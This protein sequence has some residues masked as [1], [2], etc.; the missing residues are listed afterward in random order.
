MT[1]QS[2]TAGTASSG[3]AIYLRLLGY[4]RPYWPYFALSILGYV[5]FAASQPMFPKLVDYFTTALIGDA[6]EPVSIW[7]LGQVAPEKL[8][9]IVPLGM[10]FIA[11]FRGIGSFMGNYFLARVSLGVVHDLRTH[12]FNSMLVLPNKFFDDNNSGHLI[13][14]IT[15]NVGGVTTA[16]TDAIKVVVREGLTVIA[17][18]G[19]LL[20]TN[21]KLTLLFIAIMPVIAGVVALTSKRF[22][23]LSKKIQNTMGD[24]THIASETI[25]SHRVVRSFG[26]ET[27]EK[28]RFLA[29]SAD[30]T[31]KGLKMVK[32]GAIMTPTLQLI[33]LCAMAALMY[34]VLYLQSTGATA[35]TPGQL[36]G[37]LT[38]AGLLP[39]PLRQLSEVIPN[40]QKGIVA[41]HSVFELVDEETEKDEGT[42]EVERVNG[43]LEI[44]NLT[45]TY[46]NAESPALKD[47]NFTI[48]P[49]ETIALV[50][51]SGSGKTTL[52]SLLPRFYNHDGGEILLD[53]HPIEDYQLKNLRKQI[54][55]VNQQVS[56][57]NDTVANNIA[58][59]DL[60]DTDEDDIRLAARSA[61]AMEF[62]EN[63]PEGLHTLVG[64]NG[65]LLSG[66]QRQRLA[67][68][69]AILKDAP[70]LI[71]DEATSALDTES[72]RHIQSALDNIMKNRTTL[73]IAHRLST[74][75]N[76]DR[77][78]VM[79]KG[80]IIESGTHSEL[81]ARDGAYAR[82]HHL[83]FEEQAE[84]V[85]EIIA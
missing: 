50:G 78:L 35:N 33:I 14:R 30:N 69:R 15:Y 77:I 68:A 61:Y 6:Q 55:L 43:E 80:Q 75:E 46:P 13:S 34:A 57:F 84:T 26:G 45:F 5:F 23:K 16:A 36:V 4:V 56:L 79:D 54:A 72:E 51:R 9:L 8:V 37:F 32:V 76:A 29:A 71:L 28:T 20:Y 7:G 52:A 44:R 65:V 64:E 58:Y 31:K 53:G 60:R 19:Y 70:L 11:I 40:I 73:V 85:T 74:I 42:L 67:I 49:G 48:K 39:K 59:G 81:L 38:A 22:K 66:G 27:Y 63:M 10:V 82:L 1:Q 18:L 24:V 62:I 83:Q 3:L 12:L 21:W 47:I 17:V 25:T 41:A 2:R